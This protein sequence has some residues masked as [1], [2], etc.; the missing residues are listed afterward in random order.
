MPIIHIYIDIGNFSLWVLA[1]LGADGQVCL[2]NEIATDPL[3]YYYGSAPV[4]LP[5]KWNYY[6]LYF[7]KMTN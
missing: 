2:A 6:F 1:R 3:P 4:A 7:N 5:F